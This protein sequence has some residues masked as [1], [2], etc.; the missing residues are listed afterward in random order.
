MYK[1]TNFDAWYQVLFE[2]QISIAVKEDKVTDV[3]IPNEI[4]QLIQKLH[5]VADVES[6]HVLQSG[7]PPVNASDD[8]R[9]GSESFLGPAPAGIDARYAWGFLSGDGAGTNVVDVEQ[10]WNLNHEDLAAP[11]ITL[12]SGTNSAYYFHGTSVLG[13]ILMV[14]NTI[15]GIGI[16]PAGKGR[17]ISQHQPGGYNNAA[18]ILDAAAHMSFGD[19]LLLEAQ[20]YDPVG[21]LYYWPVEI[22]D[23]TYDAIRL[24]TALGITVV[25]A[26]CNG[27]YD[28]DVYVNL[29]G[30]QIFNRSSTDFRDSGAIV[31]GAGSSA[32][33]HTRLGFSNHG[34]RIDVYGWGENV[35]TT[36]T[37]AAGTDNTLYTTGFNGTSSASPIITG[38]AMVAQGLAN[39]N[40]NYKLSP[41]QVRKI[42]AT[43]GT[44]SSNPTVDRIG[45]Q[46]N[47][48]AITDG[49][50]INLAPDL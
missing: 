35:D 43:G 45:V 47:L 12:I 13:E 9:S 29:S 40:L 5:G 25:E 49:S 28:L 15:G 1:A 14:D 2:P 27:A 41:L 24:S 48:K 19:V 39:A 4:L 37:D 7:P 44:A 16:P 17:V 34:S 36:S 32:A 26:G 3:V 30:K 22:A 20:E 10:G 50:Y 42:L 21:G 18:A 38:A 23:T 11:K 33:P 46:P 6:V 8:P 31:V